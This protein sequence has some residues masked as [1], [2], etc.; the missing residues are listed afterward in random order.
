MNDTKRDLYVSPDAKY[1]LERFSH[2]EY[3]KELNRDIFRMLDKTTYE[4]RGFTRPSGGTFLLSIVK[5]LVIG[6]RERLI[7]WHG[8][9]NGGIF[10]SD[11]II[12]KTELWNIGFS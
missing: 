10:F 6:G 2:T 5:P 1:F 8:P 7:V 12:Q 3:G 11:S 4:N 9:S